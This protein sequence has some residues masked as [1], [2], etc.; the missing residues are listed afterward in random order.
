MKCK[1]SGYLLSD[2][3]LASVCCLVEQFENQIGDLGNGR[4][5]RNIFDRCV[6][7]QCSRLAALTKPAKEDLTTFL[8]AD[9]PTPEQLAHSLL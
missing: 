1:Q 7:M 9:I 5:V 2:E 3:T 4:F 6:A 8:P